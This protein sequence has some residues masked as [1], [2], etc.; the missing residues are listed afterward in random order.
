M[1]RKCAKVHLKSGLP[2]MDM[3]RGKMW[4][5]RD[6]GLFLLTNSLENP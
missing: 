4:I 2:E 6:I 3:S 5:S 1:I